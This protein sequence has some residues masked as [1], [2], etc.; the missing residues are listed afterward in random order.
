[1]MED[2]G[3]RTRLTERVG[4]W[5]LHVFWNTRDM[6][7]HALAEHWSLPACHYLKPQRFAVLTR[8]SWLR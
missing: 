2:Y 1:M 4:L 5:I 6:V 8:S 7:E 3:V